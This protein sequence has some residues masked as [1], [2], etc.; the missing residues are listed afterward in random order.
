MHTLAR[1]AEPP[2]R[3]AGKISNEARAQIAGARGR[4]RGRARAQLIGCEERRTA[5]RETSRTT[6]ERRVPE[7][8]TDAGNALTRLSRP[9]IVLRSENLFSKLH[10]HTSTERK[11]W[12]TEH[13]DPGIDAML[14]R[15]ASRRDISCR[16]GEF[17]LSHA[18]HGTSVAFLRRRSLLHLTRDDII[19]R[20]FIR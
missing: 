17:S 16:L 18:T 7:S 6:S 19:Y 15:A 5:S 2:N 1:L 11:Q 9:A 8:E 3:T 13:L 20:S 4:A 12:S 14:T 10:L